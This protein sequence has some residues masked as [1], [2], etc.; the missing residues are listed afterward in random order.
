M[1]EPV[2]TGDALGLRR[3]GGGGL[4]AVVGAMA[5][6][7]T[8]AVAGEGAARLASAR[9]LAEGAAS[10]TALV[11]RPDEPLAAATRIGA[12][13]A[14]LRQS[15]AVA[16]ARA[17]SPEE[18]AGLVRPWLGPGAA[19]LGGL[20]LP[21]V[22]A[23]TLR[24]AGPVD[25]VERALASAVEGATLADQD[26]Q[27]GGL[28]R[29]L[30]VVRGVAAA[31]LLAVALAAAVVVGVA[32]RAALLLRREALEVAHGLGAEDGWIAGRL[33]RL[34]AWRAVVGGLVGTTLALVP[35]AAV[36]WLLP[37]LL[38]AAPLDWR[39]LPATVPPS[40]WAAV[41]GVPLAAALVGYAVAGFVARGW[42]RRLA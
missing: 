33:A 1:A 37:P 31:T 19:K 22:V 35:V 7:A 12:A 32:T 11:P 3:A 26:E 6:V 24:G 42:L 36:A 16:E 10:R 17:L 41:A 39:S 40:F 30:W 14:A 34:G 25:E 23:V 4:A 5:F 20:P 2:P 9:L 28:T 21:G 15:P 13:L 8:L 18:V 27:L 29:V 38:G